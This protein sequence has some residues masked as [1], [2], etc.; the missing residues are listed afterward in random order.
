V[1]HL[2]MKKRAVHS[3]VVLTGIG[4]VSPIGIGKT[5]FWD[6][7]VAG[8]TG[9]KPIT[10][11]DCSTYPSKLAAE[12]S[13][14][15]P[16]KY[17]TEK[18]AGRFSRATQFALVAAQQAYED[19]GIRELD[20]YRTD[21]IMGTATSAFDVL[22]KEIFKSP[23]SGREFEKGVTDPMVMIKTYANAPACAI[24]LHY[25]T[26]SYTTTVTTACASAINALG[27]AYMRIKAGETDVALTGSV[28]TPINHLIYGAF[29]AARFLTTGLTAE[30]AVAPFDKRRTKRALGEGSAVFILEDLEHALARDARIYGEIT[31]FAQSTE[32]INEIFML[33]ASGNK[34]ADH[35]RGLLKRK[36]SIRKI[37]CINAHA[38]SDRQSDAAE[39]HAIQMVFGA[40]GTKMPAHSIKGAVGQGFSVAGALQVA[41]A[42]MSIEGQIV[43]GTF[44][45]SEPDHECQVNVSRF[46]R[47]ENIS[48]VLVN[49]HGLGGIN[50]SIVLERV[51]L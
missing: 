18:T 9:I 31:G 48:S 20:P 15:D 8:E 22:E 17:M 47:T 30:T 29:C 26:Q 2:N 23:S 46:S 12:V 51:N 19:S 16:T 39:A 44:N 6:N 43:P 21:V 10:L 4:I 49:A 50:S 11:F 32:N 45:Y 34:W 36:K 13:N 35:L 40:Q 42:A 3:R 1:Q 38:P 25:Q 24:A 41:A 14:F 5:E 33:D 27:H 7:L 28:D 37:D